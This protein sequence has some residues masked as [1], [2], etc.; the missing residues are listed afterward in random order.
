MS[1]DHFV[2]FHD[3]DVE[4][5]QLLKDDVALQQLERVDFDLLDQSTFQS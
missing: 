2:S 5:F 4:G 3:S 1:F